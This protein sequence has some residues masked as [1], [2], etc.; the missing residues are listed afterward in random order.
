MNNN[1]IKH[2][3][4]K[5]VTK[6]P[7]RSIV[8][9]ISW[10]FENNSKNIYLQFLAGC[11]LKQK[12]AVENK[13]ARTFVAKTVWKHPMSIVSRNDHHKYIVHYLHMLQQN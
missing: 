1:K 3:F 2:K 10:D 6:N 7:L 12:R 4:W 8:H 5:T 9:Y 13:R 11:A